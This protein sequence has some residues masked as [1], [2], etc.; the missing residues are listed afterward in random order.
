LASGSFSFPLPSLLSRLIFRSFLSLF[1]SPRMQPVA[2][3]QIFGMSDVSFALMISKSS[4][5]TCPAF[6]FVGLVGLVNCMCACMCICVGVYV[7]A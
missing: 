7:N 3:M 6:I 5:E 4:G 2:V 1:F